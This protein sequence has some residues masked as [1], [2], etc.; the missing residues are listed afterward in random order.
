LYLCTLINQQRFTVKQE[1]TKRFFLSQ[2]KSLTNEQLKILRLLLLSQMSV[3]LS[4]CDEKKILSTFVEK[5]NKK[6][7]MTM[8]RMHLVEIRMISLKRVLSL[9]CWFFASALILIEFSFSD[10]CCQFRLLGIDIS[11]IVEMTTMYFFLFV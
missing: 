6:M 1:L 9:F 10:S 2:Q 3:C 11:G 8:T 5:I 7:T 4:V